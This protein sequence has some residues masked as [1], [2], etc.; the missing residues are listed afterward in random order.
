MQIGV[1]GFPITLQRCLF[2]FDRWR[3]TH[4]KKRI[5]KKWQKRYGSVKK[6]LHADHVYK[7]A[8]Q[9]LY[10]CRCAE[11]KFKAAVEK[12]NGR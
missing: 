5:R 9:G 7:V 6:C 4:R 10:M 3:R 11:A 2:V 1:P 8:G 12:E